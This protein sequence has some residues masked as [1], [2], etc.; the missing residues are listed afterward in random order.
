MAFFARYWNN[1]IA[2]APEP[3]R[4]ADAEIPRAAAQQIDPARA[5]EMRQ[6]VHEGFGKVA[7]AMMG[8]ARYRQLPL[9]EMQSLIIEPLLRGRIAMAQATRQGEEPN[10]TIAAIAIWASVSPEVEAKIVDQIRGNVF[11]VRL[12]AN[13][14][15]SGETPWLL[16]V[17]APNRQMTA[18]VIANLN[19][20]VP[21]ANMRLHPI[22]TKLLDAEALQKLGIQPLA[23]GPHSV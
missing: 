4:A 17:I 16:D 12:E 7:L 3:A 20:L 13:D 10:G 18:A 23:S 5:A 6:R 8:T 11:P 21:T 19:R 2:F 9:A 15:A 1:E 22:V 14:W